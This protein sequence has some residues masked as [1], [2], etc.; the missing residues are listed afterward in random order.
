MQQSRN[1]VALSSKL[2]CVGLFDTPT[3]MELL[4]P[5]P[6]NGPFRLRV[7]IQSIDG[8]PAVVGVEM[9]GVSP[10]SRIWDKDRI[11]EMKRS[12]PAEDVRIGLPDH[13]KSAL[14]AHDWFGNQSLL[15]WED[16]GQLERVEALRSAI[17]VKA[18][19]KARLTDEFLREI[20]DLCESPANREL[21]LR[22]IAE[23]FGANYNTFR[24]W[25]KRAVARR[26]PLEKE[27]LT[28]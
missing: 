3:E 15:W 24:T 11:P 23:Q 6:Q 8:R 26:A 16:E 5:H 9:W 27:G 1:T 4:H 14:A 19:G 25:K 20:L 7:W 2:P 18:T 12:I 22:E 21:S 28:L 10:V 17:A 13:L